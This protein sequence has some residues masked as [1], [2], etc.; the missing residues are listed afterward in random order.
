MML[1]SLLLIALTLTPMAAHAAKEKKAVVPSLGIA[2]V[3]NQDAIS[4]ADVGDRLRLIMISSGLPNNKETIDKITPQVING[5]IEEQLKLQEAKR[6]NI[7]ITEEDVKKGFE[8]LGAQNKMTAEQF[9]EVMKRSGVPQRTVENQIR[10]QIAWTKVIQAL[11][12]PRVDVS[13]TDVEARIARLKSQLGRT[14]FNVSEIYLPV[15]K[16]DK[17]A[18]VQMLATKLVQEL[19]KGA[20]FPA[21]AAQFSKA[22]GAQQGG[23]LGWIQDGDLPPDQ[24]QIVTTMEEQSL[25]EPI[26]AQDGFHIYWLRGKRT[27]TED[28]IPSREELT[29]SIGMERLDREQQR[30]LSD[31]KS[32]AFIE[33]RV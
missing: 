8:A 14:E 31:L 23:A 1:R 21:V 9:F 26:R 15:A 7:E 29:N 28:K 22:P 19:K 17:E 18:D 27:L 33:Y 5:L 24:N 13:E 3:V 2:A 32:S 16:G 4:M 11:L 25:S 12:R 6:N 10:A 30:H 20:P